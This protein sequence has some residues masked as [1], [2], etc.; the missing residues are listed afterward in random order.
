MPHG[1]RLWNGVV[2]AVGE[3][4]AAADTAQSEPAA[5]EPAMTNDS[6]VGVFTARWKELAMRGYKHVKKRR[7]S[8]FVEREHCCG[9]TFAAMLCV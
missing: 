9:G 1:F 8:S 5:V 4:M 7:E 3:R 6:N 2:T